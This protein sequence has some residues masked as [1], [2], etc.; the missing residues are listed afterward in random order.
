MCKTGTRLSYVIKFGKETMRNM[1]IPNIWD[2]EEPEPEFT[3]KFM[4]VNKG[5]SNYYR[6]LYEFSSDLCNDIRSR[7]QDV[8]LVDGVVGGGGKSS[9]RVSKVYWIPKTQKFIDIYSKLFDLIARAN[10]ASFHFRIEEIVTN[11]QYTVY[12]ESYKGHYGWHIDVGP[13]NSRR[14]LSV[15][16]QLSDP[17]EYEGGEL[18]IWTGA[19]EPITV[20]KSKG[21]VIIFP[22]F[23]L[24]QVTPVT[25]GTRRTLVL[26]VDGPPFV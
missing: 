24:H 4:T 2:M 7:L 17:S 9:I 1:E 15:V 12:E 13:T 16:V 20:E 8:P 3:F 25:K 23:L 10:D 19:T 14:K 22:S 21:T 18:Q 11:I 26:W 6:Y 5:V